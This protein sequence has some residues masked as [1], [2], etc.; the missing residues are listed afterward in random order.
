MIRNGLEM[1]IGGKRSTGGNDRKGRLYKAIE[2]LP[3]DGFDKPRILH[4][5]AVLP[6]ERFAPLGSSLSLIS[7]ARCISD[8]RRRRKSAIRPSSSAVKDAWL[9]TAGGS[10]IMPSDRI[11]VINEACALAS[12]LSAA[13]TIVMITAAS[14]VTERLRSPSRILIR[15]F[16]ASL[17]TVRTLRC[18]FGRPLGFPEWPGLR[19]RPDCCGRRIHIRR[20]PL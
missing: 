17:T 16:N 14:L 9:L 19:R 20:G 2:V 1:P 3:Q 6:F 4:H 7:V 8:P 10:P 13:L 18:P 12:P 5:N 15:W 11:I